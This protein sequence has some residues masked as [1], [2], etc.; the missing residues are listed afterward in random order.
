MRLKIFFITG[1]TACIAA[2]SH[3]ATLN[4]VSVSNGGIGDPTCGAVQTVSDTGSGAVSAVYVNSTP[5][6]RTGGEAQ[7]FGGGIGIKGTATNAPDAPSSGSTIRA[8]AS[9]TMNGIYIRP[10]Q[11][12][13]GTQDFLISVGLNAVLDGVLFSSIN[14]AV[15][16]ARGSGAGI[17]AS[18]KLNGIENFPFDLSS[19]T[20]VFDPTVG[21]T[22]D[23]GDA[24]KSL[25]L[26]SN[27]RPS[28][29]HDWR[30]PL[31]I[32]FVLNGRAGAFGGGDSTG[33]GT[34][35][36]LNTLSF[37]EVGPAFF[38]PDGFTVDAP[39]LNILDNQWTDPRTAI[40]TVPLP[41]GL[42][43]M[44]L[45]LCTFSFVGRSRQT[46]TRRS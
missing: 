22:N 16:F 23:L 41:A 38:L 6:C 43:L 7:A 27:L 21:V 25:V 30:N 24:S 44:V 14:S 35:D 28:V 18:V 17:F 40:S 12:N 3:A 32:T 11:Q 42:P 39:E 1:L 29:M 20:R 26:S 4:S 46:P 34:F 15:P 8:S 13:A 10:T 33:T 31:S 9:S 45:G 19:D 2:V 36:T 37:S 5:G